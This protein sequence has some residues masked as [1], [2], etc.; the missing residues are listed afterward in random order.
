MS[1][2]AASAIKHHREQA[3]KLQAEIDRLSDPAWLA[4]EIAAKVK[5]RDQWI[6]L[7]DELASYGDSGLWD[8]KEG[9]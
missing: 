7:A 5:R 2:W 1:N 8:D 3:D 4:R 9:K 6:R